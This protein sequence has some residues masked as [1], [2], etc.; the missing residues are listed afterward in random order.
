VVFKD[1]NWD[2]VQLDPAADVVRARIADGGSI[3]MTDP[4]L[5]A[6][7]ARGGKLLLWHGWSDGSIPPLN[8]VNYYNDVMATVGKGPAAEQIRLIM[9]PGVQHCAGGEGAW[10]VDFLS[11]IDEWVER[12]N[13]PQRIAASRP[14]N[15]GRIRGRLLCPYPQTAA[16]SGQGSTDEAAN[17]VC[18]SPH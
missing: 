9:A 3:A 13:A 17:F 12:G 10:Q 8:T 16:Y 1:P 18:K 11:V 15:D 4:D 14:L 2:P 6:F 5:R 7:L